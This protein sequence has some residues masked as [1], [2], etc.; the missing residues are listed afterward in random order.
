[1]RGEKINTLD[2]LWKAVVDKKAVVTNTCMGR[3]PAAFV[4]NMQGR[5]I[6]RLIAKGMYV[7]RPRNNGDD[8]NDTTRKA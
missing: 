7:Y 4:I 6:H 5:E 3:M 1:M 2:D 8:G